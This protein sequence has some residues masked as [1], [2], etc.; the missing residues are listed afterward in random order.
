MEREGGSPRRVWFWRVGSFT[1]G[2]FYGDGKDLLKR[3]SVVG[4]RGELLELGLSLESGD[5]SS[6]VM[7]DMASFGTSI[8]FSI[9]LGV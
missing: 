9:F 2:R 1:R 7:V 4:G 6:A 8:L 5:V 3:A